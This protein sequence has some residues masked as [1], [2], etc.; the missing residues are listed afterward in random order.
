M[1]IL[2]LVC[3]AFCT[4]NI[5]EG[6]Y[7]VTEE[8]FE[9]FIEF[10]KSRNATFYLKF[11]TPMCPHCQTL[12]P[13]YIEAA[14]QLQNDPD[15]LYI[16][17]EVNTMINERLGKHFQIRGLPTIFTFSPLNDY[18]PVTYA[19]N[20]TVF[21]LV[22]EIELASGL[23]NKE[24]KTYADFEYRLGMRNENMMVGVFKDNKNKLFTEMQ[25][26][27]EEFK[28]IRMY[29][30]FNMEEFRQK[31]K[32]PE[33][34]NFVLMF[35]DKKFI[36][37]GD[38]PYTI[39]TPEKY[40][41]MRDFV[42]KEYPYKVEIQN[43]KVESIF[44][45]RNNLPRAVLFTP[46][47][48]RSKEVQ[49]L[50]LQMK[51]LGRKFDGKINVYLQDADPKMVRK[52]R[53]LG[54]STFIIF[55]TDKEASKYRYDAKVFEDKIDVDSLIEFTQRFL[56]GR[57]PK[58]IRSAEV[59][60]DDLDEPVYPVVAK[61]YEQVVNDPTKHVFLRFF[62]KMVQRYSD[63]FT[64]RKEWWKVGKNFTGNKKDLLIAE[65]ET[66]DN[67]VP[68]YFAKEMAAGH[69]YFLFTKK[70]K[71]EPYIYKGKISAVDMIKF[72]EDTIAK[73]DPAMKVDL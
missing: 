68:G 55:D 22:T 59:N 31:L 49:E 58:Y 67:D 71:T 69:Y 24:L 50:A 52:F 45:L 38:A 40:K 56:E 6:I 11:Y 12:R 18:M 14:K 21:D 8:N 73:E 28:F 29:Y 4:L 63:Q 44:A 13:L 51:P 27:K 3:G 61:T 26:I 35:H 20:K 15:G 5:K 16:L 54:N 17:G 34:E 7:N 1:V 37:S 25:E 46:F 47:V 32:L 48:N 43:D 53:L 62:D 23:S 42:I 39:Y 64:M 10:A 41:T 72:A 66:N 2:A 30:T 57:V 19:R 9:E 65:I 36:E 60:K 33:G 70:Q